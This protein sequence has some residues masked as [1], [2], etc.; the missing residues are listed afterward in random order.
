M[1][2]YVATL[3]FLMVAMAAWEIRNPKANR[4]T[5]F[6]HFTDVVT[7]QRLPQFQE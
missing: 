6:T 5:F 4:A 2:V 1:W 3:A 7:F